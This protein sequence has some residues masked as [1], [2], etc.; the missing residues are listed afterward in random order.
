MQ[1]GGLAQRRSRWPFSRL[2]PFLQRQL[3]QAYSS[4]RIRQRSVNRVRSRSGSTRFTGR[5]AGVGVHFVFVDERRKGSPPPLAAVREE[6]Q[7]E[8]LKARG[9]WIRGT[10]PAVASPAEART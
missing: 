6:V 3:D 7:R 9:K 4:R 8:W 2:S 10:D 1:C 5:D